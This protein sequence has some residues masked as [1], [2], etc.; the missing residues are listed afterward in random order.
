MTRIDWN[1]VGTAAGGGLAIILVGAALSAP[2]ADRAGGWM[3][4]AF[5]AIALLGFALAGAVAGRLRNDT[6]L[7]HGA[8][9]AGV[10]FLVALAIGLT[11][12]SITDRPIALAALPIGAAAAVTTGVAGAL[13][14]DA[15]HR[16]GRHRPAGSG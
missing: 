13:T 15:L 12:A 1:A 16:R 2:L 4:W 10:T 11:I 14:A 7:V 5:L 3:A 6:P 9:G 8:A